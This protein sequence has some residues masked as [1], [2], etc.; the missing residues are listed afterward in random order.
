MP[1]KKIGRKISCADLLALI[2]QKLIRNLEEKT[3]VNYQ[4][5]K[6]SGDLTLKLIL[7]SLLNSEKVSLRIMEH[8]YQSNKFKVF[9][10]HNNKEV[11]HSGI[12]NRIAT[13]NYRFFQKIFEHLVKHSDLLTENKN[14]LDILK[15]DS[16]VVNLS[17]KLLGFGMRQEESKR[18]VKFT[19]ELKNFFPTN[20]KFFKKQKEISEEIALKKTIFGSKYT[21]N[22]IVV[23][24]RGLQS[25][26]AFDK[27]SDK[28]IRFITRLKSRLRFK[29]VGKFK[30]VAGQKTS[31]LCLEKDIM[32]KL[33][34]EDEKW[35]KNTFRLIIA[36]SLKNNEP[37]IFLTNIENLTAEEITDIYKER[38]GI[39]V[40]F[41]FLKQELNF[42]HLVS[43]NENGIKVMLYA[44]LI[45]AFLI[46]VYKEKNKIIGYRIAKIKFADE[47]EME[48]VKEIVRCCKGNIHNFFNPKSLYPT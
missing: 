20:V 37:I 15:F 38:W 4:A 27:L 41:K 3:K 10:K 39:E 6:L 32:V 43:R 45:L 24:D 44:T 12:A 34:N 18:F 29:E 1:Q 25:R 31:T 42:K 8:I 13:I 19:V 17:A 11:G 40:F 35:T 21:K 28:N 2:P 47:L 14:N 26:K 36:R 33:K 5:K 9:A 30:Q 16:T 22:S 7:F 46:L 48:I 23:F